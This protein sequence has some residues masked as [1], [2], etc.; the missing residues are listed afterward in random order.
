MRAGLI[1]AVGNPRDRFSE[2]PLRIVRAAR[3]RG[4]YGFEVDAGTFAAM[5]EWSGKLENVSGRKDSG[6]NIKILTARDISGAFGLLRKSGA[7]GKVLPCLDEGLHITAH[8]GTGAGI[9]EHTLTCIVNSPKRP[10]IRLAALFH[11]IALPALN[12]TEEGLPS[13]FAAR[14]PS[15]PGKQ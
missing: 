11:Q 1:R 13:D 3:M 10:R 12:T 4:I 8:T 2:D 15:A 6:R 7:F 5:R 9:Y 14:A